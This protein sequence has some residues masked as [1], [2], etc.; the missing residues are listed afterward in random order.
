MNNLVLCAFDPANPRHVVQGENAPILV[1]NLPGAIDRNGVPTADSAAVDAG[2]EIPGVTDGFAGEAPDVGAYERGAPYWRPGADWAPQTTQPELAFVPQPPVAEENMPAEGLLLW[3]DGKATSTLELAE[4]HL[5]RWRDRLRP[6]TAAEAGSGFVPLAEGGVRSAGEAALTVGTLRKESGPATVFLVARSDR[7]D[8]RPW[9]R[10]FVAWSGEGNDWVAPNFQQMRPGGQTPAAFPWRLFVL[11]PQEAVLDH[12]TLAASAQ[13]ET[14]NFL[15][16]LGEVLVFDH[17][18][19]FD[20][21]QAIA[22][23]L[24]RKWGIGGK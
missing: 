16:D 8:P 21:E 23:Y 19:P 2:V 14:Q 6:E 12:I 13:Q 4:G 9:Q 24:R 17:T 22:D 11:K 1:A 10:L 15:G 20:R 18:L 3:L 7:V 5:L